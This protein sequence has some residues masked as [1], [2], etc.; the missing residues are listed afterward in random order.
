[1][2]VW[3]SSGS[4]YLGYIKLSE[5]IGSFKK[6]KFGKFSTIVFQNFHLFIC[7]LLAVLR[8]C[9]C[10]GFSLVVMQGL[11]IAVAS[12]VAEENFFW[13]SLPLGSRVQVHGCSTQP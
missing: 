11:L 4:T 12:L 5:S 9:C 1:M 2:W 8:L 13:A 3:I 6:F 10:S 7:L